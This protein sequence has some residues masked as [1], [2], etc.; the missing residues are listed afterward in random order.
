MPLEQRHPPV[1]PP[2]AIAAPPR[3]LGIS[4]L[5]LSVAALAAFVWPESLSDY[6]AL[7]WLLALVPCFLLAYHKG[8]KG[9]ATATAAAMILLVVVEVLVVWLFGNRVVDW[10]VFASVSVVLITVNLGIGVVSELH[11]RD[12]VSA[13]ALAYTDA[14]TG[15]PNRRVLDEFMTRYFAAAERGRPFT[16]VMFDVDGFKRYNDRYGHAC[17]DDAL[18]VVSRILESNT[19]GMDLSGRYGGE[20]FVTLLPGSVA[21]DARVFAE[22]VRGAIETCRE[23][24]GKGLTVSAG[25]AEYEATM[26]TPKELLEAADDALYRAKDTG[27]NA[28]MIAGAGSEAAEVGAA[29]S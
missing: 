23:F 3:V 1:E 2:G 13:S 15:I 27:R 18:R 10:R 20:E 24:H 19:R 14:L 16:A 9:A 17:G 8:W 22:R 26:G 21:A 5:A 25:I 11:L 12:K 7:V 29:E 28:V 6:S 4:V